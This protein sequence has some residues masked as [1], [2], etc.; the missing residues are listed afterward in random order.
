MTSLPPVASSPDESSV[1]ASVAR[2]HGVLGRI[3]RAIV[4]RRGA[5]LGVIVLALL[6]LVA[7]LAPWI[8]PHDPLQTDLDR[9]FMAPFQTWS[10]PLGTDDLGRDVLSRLMHGARIS[11][12]APVIA[13]A[14]MIP[15]GVLPG[16]LAGYVGGRLDA[17]VMRIADSLMAFPPVILAIGVIGVLG[18]GLQNAM[19]AIGVVYAP[20]LLR[21]IRTSVVAVRRETYTE[22]AWTL[23]ASHARILRRHVLPNAAG[24]LVIQISFA[25]AFAMLAEAGLSFLGLGVQPPEASWGAMLGRAFEFISVSSWAMF[26]P[27]VAIVICVLSLNTIGEAVREG[28]GLRRVR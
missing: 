13:V 21:L 15:V 26:W 11:L 23:D 8:S 6:T 19:L 27:G 22:A 16:I 2:A 4:R 7:V 24:P 1:S 9:T 28:L 14:V 12:L 5:L 25:A 10:H 17:V 3:G 18:A 20:R